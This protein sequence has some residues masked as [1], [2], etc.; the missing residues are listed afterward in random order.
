MVRAFMNRR[1]LFKIADS[2]EELGLL[3]QWGNPLRGFTA[4]DQPY[5][6]RTAQV[7]EYSSV[8]P[9][10]VSD[11]PTDEEFQGN[12]KYDV[13]AFLSGN[14]VTPTAEQLEVLTSFSPRSKG[15]LNG[16]DGFWFGTANNLKTSLF[17]PFARYRSTDGKINTN[18]TFLALWSSKYMDNDEASFLSISNTSVQRVGVSWKRCAFSIRPVKSEAFVWDGVSPKDYIEIGGVK[19]A[20]GNVTGYK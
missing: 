12:E 13:C 2:P 18:S 3:F 10:Y 1:K 7:G 8:Y 16:V 19:W 5:S 17:F 6:N 11:M 9:A 4:D 14:W 20:K 15:V